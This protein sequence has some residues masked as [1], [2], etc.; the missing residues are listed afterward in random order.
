MPFFTTDDHVQLFYDDRGSG[1]PV[2][3]IH[4]LTANH[5]H[6]RKQIPSLGRRFRV[7][8]PDLRGHGDSD[9][10]RD[11]LTIP[12]LA[13][14][15]RGLVTHLGLDAVTLV[16]WSMGGHVIFEYI[17]HFG[18]HGLEGIAVVD[19]APKLMKA[20]DW[21][22]GLRGISGQTGDFSHE[23]NL[24]LMSRMCGNWEEYCTL[25]IPRLFNRSDVDR[26]IDI[27]E[28]PGFSWKGDLGWLLEEARRNSPHV[29]VF[30]W[31]S[32]MMQDYRPELAEITIPC[33]LVWGR[34]SNYYGEET[35]RFMEAALVNAP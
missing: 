32:L 10:P 16:G 27:F 9:R 28:E 20:D 7:I 19:M 35:Y 22:L 1:K 15:L 14:D 5:S 8:A 30:L 4:G 18:C 3:L 17:R 2:I 13:L 33:L 24:L 31:I 26:G 12:R 29:I 11:G 25:L 6:F 23:D 21:S 34:E